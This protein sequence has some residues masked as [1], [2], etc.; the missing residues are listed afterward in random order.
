[1][2]GW[3]DGWMDGLMDEHISAH[4]KRYE[5]EEKN[6]ASRAWNSSRDFRTR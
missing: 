3:I 2:D 1:M 5:K 4:P 6:C